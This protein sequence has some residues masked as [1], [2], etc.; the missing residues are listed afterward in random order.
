[1][2]KKTKKT[3]R[4][5]Q[6]QRQKQSVNV[7]VHIDQSKR[8]AQRQPSQQNKGRFPAPH[9]QSLPYPSMV[10]NSPQLPLADNRP[11][12]EELTTTNQLINALVTKTTQPPQFDYDSMYNYMKD[13]VNREHNQRAQNNINPSNVSFPTD[14]NS[15]RVHD[16]STLYLDN[17]IPSQFQE[18]RQLTNTGLTASAGMISAE[19]LD[20]DVDDA[21]EQLK[22]I[23]SVQATVNTALKTPSKTPKKNNEL[24]PDTDD[25][26]ILP[27]EDV[28]KQ[29]IEKVQQQEKKLNAGLA[30]LSKMRAM[31][32]EELADYKEEKKRIKATQK[33][34]IKEQAQEEELQRKE[35]GLPKKKGRPPKI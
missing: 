30:E 17:N 25:Y 12:T 6:K 29:K 24:F 4:T 28:I 3:K 14:D 8:T 10:F 26:L 18:P 11:K 19:S 20:D 9:I 35:Q 5:T 22:G 16:G 34:Q 1:M 23:G 2:P 31:S 21:Y 7:K 13:R 15:P 33:Q 32:R 27:T